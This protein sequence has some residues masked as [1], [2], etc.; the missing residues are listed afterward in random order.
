[1]PCLSENELIW[2]ACELVSR[3]LVPLFWWLHVLIN[4]SQEYDIII[5]NIYSSQVIKANGFLNGMSS[6]LNQQKKWQ[7]IEG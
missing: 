6:L 1:M 7:L 5:M 2:N 3:L 4:A